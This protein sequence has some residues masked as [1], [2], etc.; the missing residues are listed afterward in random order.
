M[1][2][3][4]PNL[5][6]RALIL[7]LVFSLTAC[8]G[9]KANEPIPVAVVASHVT[10]NA[11]SSIQFTAQ[12]APVDGAEPSYEWNFG[13]GTTSTEDAV[14]HTFDTAGTFEVTLT[15]RA[16]GRRG[17]DTI[18]IELNEP[19]NLVVADVVVS[20]V[21]ATAGDEIQVSW[22]VSN[23]AEPVIGEWGHAVISVSG[24]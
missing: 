20:P 12:V 18:Q 1:N 13:D 23:L 8:G 19:A 7:S 17:A 3:R 15:V 2:E 21:R 10:G 6:R 24:P 9:D 5:W 14:A 16:A 4:D 11:P 22:S